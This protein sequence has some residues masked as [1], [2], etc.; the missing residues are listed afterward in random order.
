MTEYENI[1]ERLL[2]AVHIMTDPNLRKT[3]TAQ[4]LYIDWDEVAASM[5]SSSRPKETFLKP[6]PPANPVSRFSGPL[7]TTPFQ[8]I[9]EADAAR[10]ADVDKVA[11]VVLRDAPQPLTQIR[12]DVNRLIRESANQSMTTSEAFSRLVGIVEQIVMRLENVPTFNWTIPS[13]APFPMVPSGYPANLP[14]KFA[15]GYPPTYIGDPPFPTHQTIC[16]SSTSNAVPQADGHVST[17]EDDSIP[18]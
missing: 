13:I 6:I 14:N 5:K 16:K 2:D 10:L 17:V 1:R 8:H 18:F 3:L 15:P 4:A 12:E 11:P 9:A 7:R